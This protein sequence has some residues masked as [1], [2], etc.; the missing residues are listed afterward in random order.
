MR[1]GSSPARAA[2]PPAPAPGSSPGGGGGGRGHSTAHDPWAREDPRGPLAPVSPQSLWREPHPD[3]Q[4]GAQVD[5]TAA[6]C[7]RRRPTLLFPSPAKTPGAPLGP[8]VH[9]PGRVTVNPKRGSVSAAGSLGPGRGPR[10]RRGRN[11]DRDTDRPIEAQTEA[12]VL[13]RWVCGSRAFGVGKRVPS[14]HA[15]SDPQRQ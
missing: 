13:I 4:T 9:G 10:R 5:R 1:G 12:K 7:R 6:G 2:Q 8:R 11:T 3:S 14:I 15:R